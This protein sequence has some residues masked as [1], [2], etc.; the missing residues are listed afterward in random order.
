MNH[1]IKNTY[2]RNIGRNLY[3][4]ECVKISDNLDSVFHDIRNMKV[5]YFTFIYCEKGDLI[6]E[7]NNTVF[8][9]YKNDI[10]VCLP[11]SLVTQIE[12]KHELKLKIIRFSNRFAHRMTQTEKGTW[13]VMEH[14]HLNPVRHL[15]KK[16]SYVL[17]KYVELV[18]EKQ[19][20]TTD[21]FQ[22]DILIYIA[23]AMFGEMI[24]MAH[25][26]SGKDNTKDK[27]ED[28]L[29]QSDYI[30][31]NFMEAVTADKG[32][33]RTIGYY[34]EMLCYTPKYLSSI[35]KKVC[36]KNALTLINEN[37]VEHIIA[38]LKY[39]DKNIKQIAFDF[40]FSNNAFFS[41]F[42]KLHTGISPTEYRNRNSR[43]E[44]R[45][46]ETERKSDN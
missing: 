7:L 37:A 42:F 33:H 23:S 3:D 39:T 35:V 36:G 25:K 1:D 41:K 40:N 24:A 38:E 22:K 28:S 34:A 4:D 45:L 26:N 10:L 27:A 46:T 32:R 14:L 13:K 21:K 18:S 2:K 5:E 43:N 30:F 16:E 8:H 19:K 20:E 9:L 29:R 11:N 17:K 15:N 6:I 12:V 31:N 44:D